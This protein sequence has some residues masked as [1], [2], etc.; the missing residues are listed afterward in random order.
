MH[1]SCP[2]LARLLHIWKADLSSTNHVSGPLAT[3]DR[4]ERTTKAIFDAEVLAGRKKKVRKLYIYVYI[5]CGLY[6]VAHALM[7][8]CF[9]VCGG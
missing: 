4:A 8:D 6:S 3:S 9:H 2:G 5:I 7:R 1:F